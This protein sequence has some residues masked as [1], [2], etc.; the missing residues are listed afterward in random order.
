MMSA[1]NLIAV[2]IILSGWGYF[3]FGSPIIR[4][5][6]P[7]D[8][9]NELIIQTGPNGG[10]IAKLDRE[11][12]KSAFKKAGLP[13]PPNFGGADPVPVRKLLEAYTSWVTTH[14]PKAL[15]DMGMIFQ[16]LE[17]HEPA[18]QCFAALLELDP[19]NTLWRYF[20]GTES[21]ALGMEEAAISFLEQ[22]LN[23]DKDY[24][25]TYARLGSLYLADNDLD[26]AESNYEKYRQMLPNQSLSYIGLGR[27]E[28]ARDNTV[29]AEWFFRQAVEATTNDYMAYRMLSRAL[30]RNSKADEARTISLIADRQPQYR[31]WLVFDSRLMDSHALAQTQRYLENQMRLAQGDDVKKLI[32]LGEQLLERRPSDSNTMGLVAEGYAT[33]NK[34]DKAQK[35]VDHSLELAPDS[36]RILCLRARIL[37]FSGNIDEAYKALGDALALDNKFANAYELRGS[38]MYNQSRFAEARVALEKCVELDPIAMDARMVLVDILLRN[39]EFAQAR[40]YLR[41]IQQIDPNNF[42]ANRLLQSLPQN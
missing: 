17:E 29:A 18:L 23:D 2:V 13:E 8:L 26:K 9:L 40:K 15:A 42:T 39:N 4:D 19:S 34:F 22:T 31:G 21:Q 36:L 35:L 12:C 16:A 7:I 20:A 28:M 24:A 38:F 27:V 14:N 6:E 41:Q 32:A 3:I 10:P 1:R 5:D 11:L 25:T 33:L 37:F 30:S